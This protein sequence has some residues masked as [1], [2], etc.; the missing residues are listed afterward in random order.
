M[1]RCVKALSVLSS[2]FPD[3]SSL[4][5]APASRFKSLEIPVRHFSTREWELQTAR[6]TGNETWYGGPPRNDW[7]WVNYN[8][9]YHPDTF[10]NSERAR[11]QKRRMEAEKGR[12]S[13]KYGA[14]R[15]R[16]PGQLLCLFKLVDPN[17]EVW[18]LALIHSTSAYQSGAVDSASGLVRVV[19]KTGGVQSNLKLV[20]ASRIDGCAHL[21]PEDPGPGNKV[22]WV[23]SVIDLTTWNTI[24]EYDD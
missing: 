1:Y 12:N 13:V 2:R 10:R 23:N 17:G 21:V 6:S 9:D 14:L 15:G 8:E 19:N 20:S 16:L 24:Y 22:W 7:V 5:S 11:T 3:E 18:H 4:W